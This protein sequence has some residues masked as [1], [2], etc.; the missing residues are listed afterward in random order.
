MQQAL[1][2]PERLPW[3]LLQMLHSV[4]LQPLAR[5][6]MRSARTFSQQAA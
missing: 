6:A 4:P 3:R 5:S 2:E 1:E